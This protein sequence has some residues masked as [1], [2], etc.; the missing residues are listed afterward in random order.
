MALCRV[1]VAGEFD[2]RNAGPYGG[3][4]GGAFS[5]VVDG[6]KAHVKKIVIR[7]GKRLDSIQVT[8]K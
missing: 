2:C 5:E 7:S 1:H 4:G 6:C 3:G 8:Y